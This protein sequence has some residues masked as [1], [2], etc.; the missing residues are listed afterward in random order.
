MNG[1]TG[2]GAPGWLRAV[3]VLAVA[4]NVVGVWNYL[5]YVGVAGG[6]LPGPAMPAL[7]TAAF[8][9]GVFAGVAGSVGLV[10]ARNWALPLL[11]LSL[12]A[13]VINWGWVL[14]YSPAAEPVLGAAVLA[15]AAGFAALAWV[16][17]RRGWLG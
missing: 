5:V 9:T 7:V 15:A 16:A 10:A 1:M 14:A 8:A 3:G 2:A 6:A 17:R 13:A 11:L 4:W 12:A